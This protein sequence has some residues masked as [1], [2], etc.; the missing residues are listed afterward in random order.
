M[1][2]HHQADPPAVLPGDIVQVTD[3]A[4]RWYLALL[5]VEQVHKWGLAAHANQMTDDGVKPAYCRI[6]HG[7][8]ALVGTAALVEGELAQARKVAVAA[9]REIAKESK[10]GEKGN[11][12]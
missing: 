1:A 5:I 12:Q 8:Y 4:E 2:S 6:A 9:A 11:A 10:Q 3:P 7:K